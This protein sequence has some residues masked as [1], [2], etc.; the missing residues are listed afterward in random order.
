MGIKS[1]IF[2]Y[3]IISIVFI[4]F[5]SCFL[6]EN[7]KAQQADIDF[8]GEPTYFL[9]KEVIK[10]DEVIGRSYIINVTLRNSGDLKSEEMTIN[11]TDIEGFSIH[12]LTYFEPGEIKTITFHWST[13][14][15]QDQQVILSY[16]PSAPGADRN[17]YNSGSK[18]LIIKV[19]S[20]ISNESTPGFEL[21]FSFLA[22]IIVIFVLSKKNYR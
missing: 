15:L 19:P 17:Q 4:S 3:L 12:D 21:I 9:T 11:L 8:I 14:I 13:I 22:I 16:F 10:N 6:I 2:L 7:V 1:K 5:F 18:T 20:E